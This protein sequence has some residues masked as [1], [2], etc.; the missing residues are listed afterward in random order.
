MLLPRLTAAGG[1]LAVLVTVAMIGALDLT[2]GAVSRTISVYALGPYRWVFDSA[3]LLLAAG[4]LAILGVLV[5][6]GLTSWR[7]GG[8]IFLQLWAVGLALVVAFPKHNWAVGPSMSGSI[9]RFA[10]L[11][12][13]VSLPVALVLLAR[14][15]LRHA[16]WASH[17]RWTLGAGVLSV[18]AFAPILY[19]VGV[20]VAVGTAWWRVFPLGYTE[21]LLVATEVAALLI[22]GVWALASTASPA[23]P[24]SASRSPAAVA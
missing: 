9:H 4:S 5:H 19:A 8:A 22:L 24:R 17:A 6:R 21:R 14:P 15:W 7:S 2:V 23:R 10:S 16:R 12:A 1:S 11:L 20:N 13:F 18:L 3:V